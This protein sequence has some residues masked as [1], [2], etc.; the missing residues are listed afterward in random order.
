VFIGKRMDIVLKEIIEDKLAERESA[1][2]ITSKGASRPL[3]TKEKDSIGM[4]RAGKTFVQ[5]GMRLR[6]R[7]I[8]FS[9][10][11]G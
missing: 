1:R 4:T 3:W 8:R 6:N 11:E 5:S 7:Q 10:I 9:R 2:L